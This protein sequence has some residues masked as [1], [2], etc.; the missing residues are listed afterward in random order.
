MTPAPPSW[1]PRVV[2]DTTPVDLIR[3]ELPELPA[4]TRDRSVR[5]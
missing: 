4:L 5:S 2:R 1:R 3:A